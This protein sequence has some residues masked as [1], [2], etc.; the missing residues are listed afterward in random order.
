MRIYG[1]I[2][3]LSIGHACI[4]L[5]LAFV[6]VLIRYYLASRRPKDFPPGPP[7]V[8]FLGNITQ[9]PT[10][11][12]F[13]KFRDMQAEYGSIIGLKIGSQ[14]FVVLNSYKHVKALY[15]ERG[16]IYSSRA[17]AYLANEILCP[18]EIHILLM[19]YGKEWRKQRKILQSLLSVSVV[20]KLLPLQ[21]AETTQTMFQ[22]LQ[23]PD[24]YYDHIRRY[25]T[26]VIL[27]SVYGQ[28]GSSF[29]HPNVQALY[30]A[31]DQFTALLEQGASP[32]VDAFPF[33]RAV[34][35][36]LA[37]W[38]IKGRLV[39]EE[40]KR[41]YLRLVQETR[42][43]LRR[44]KG[45]D[46]FLKSMLD[47]QKKNEMDDEHVAY[48]A[49]NLMEAGSDTTASTLLSFLLAMIR[50]PAEF[51]K[52]QQEVDE[53]CGSAKSPTARDI[54]RLPFIKAC[55]YETLRW[56]PVAPG[57]VPHALTKDDTYEGYF[58]PKGTIV[59]ANTWAIHN[60]E[61]EYE[62]PHEFMPDRFMNNEY[63]TRYPI[64]ED[65]DS[66]R[67]T[68]YAFGAGRRVCPG[69]RLAK[70]SMMLNMA[71]IAWTFNLA[72]N[73]SAVND[74]IDSAYHDG[75]LIAP[76]K[77]PIKITPRTE[78]HKEVIMNEYDSIQSFWDKY[79]D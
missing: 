62:R 50:Y 1:T 34:P 49:G 9:V 23:D 5:V 29:N 42:D 21:E 76:K 59:L 11:K 20:D 67:R 41:L 7:T 8:P 17:N 30:H 15:D 14:N 55:M 31:Q 51:K 66:H 63:G 28:R 68:L 43:R 4:V 38:K 19:Q 47:G 12:A 36:F 6:V 58:L 78:R 54:D 2:E 35:E 10:S 71:K 3:L 64:D 33:L 27:A 60:D 56:R 22:L 77:F 39:R 73:S 18:N 24:G 69:Q 70:N 53:V 13:L 32:P 26:A 72:S 52:A 65:K 16:A 44:G 45:G 48:L 75:F 57:G 25:T 40:Q 61:A 74:D 79:D 37:S 46:S